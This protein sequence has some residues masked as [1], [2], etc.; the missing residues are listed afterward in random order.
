MPIDKDDPDFVTALARGLTVFTCFGQDSE[1]LTLSEVAERSGL[2]RAASRRILLTLESLG[3]VLARGRHFRLAPKTLDL[4]YAYLSSIP[5][6][7]VAQPIMKEVVDQ[8]DESCSIGVL[9]GTDVVYIARIPPK[10][11]MFIPVSMGTRMD[12]YVNSLGRVLLAAYSPAELDAYFEKIKIT[13]HSSH[14]LDTEAQLRAE[15]VK[16]ARDD[17]AIIDQELQ[18]GYRSIAVPIPSRSGP[19]QVALNA[20]AHASRATKEELVSRILPVL[21]QAAAR[22]SHAT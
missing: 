7:R 13:K 2:N 16:V 3:Y 17:Y 11:F 18:E 5:V 9:D 20:S 21:Q 12:A 15:L 10:H 8:L 19:V 6:W 4:G 1:E 22:I 14:S